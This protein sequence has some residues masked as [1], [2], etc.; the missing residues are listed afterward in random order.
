MIVRVAVAAGGVK[1][2]ANCAVALKVTVAVLP[3]GLA[4][5]L[6]GNVWLGVPPAFGTTTLAGME[7]YGLVGPSVSVRMP[8]G[9]GTVGAVPVCVIASVT[10]VAASALKV[11]VTIPLTA[12]DGE[13][14]VRV[15]DAG[16][17]VSV[18]TATGATLN[19]L[20]KSLA[21]APLPEG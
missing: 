8:V 18:G 5:I 19:Q 3:P 14:A 11:S 7:T 2:L 9:E 1:P 4:V 6:I 17:I 21:L 10:V 15:T 16:E 12:G 13:A 20:S